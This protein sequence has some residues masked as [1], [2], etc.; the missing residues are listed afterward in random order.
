M[1]MSKKI[2][3]RTVA[4][5]CAALMPLSVLAQDSPAE[6][7]L[8]EIVVTAQKRE[9]RLQDVPIAVSV[10]SGAIAESGGGFN[11][12]ALRSLVPSLNIRKTNTSLNQSL[13]LR[14]VG[15]INF[16]IAAQPSVATVLDGV[17]LSS[18][19]EAFGDLYDIE[20]VEVLRGPQGTLFGK[21]ASAGVVNIVSKRPGDT[22]GGYVDFGWY[23]DNE[24][25]IESVGRDPSCFTRELPVAKGPFVL[26]LAM[27]STAKG[28]GQIFFT[29]APKDGFG[30]AKSVNFS[31]T[32]DGGYH[33]YKIALGDAAHLYALRIDPATAPGSVTIRSLVLRDASGA[34]AKT[35]KLAEA[36]A[37]KVVKHVTPNVLFI[38]LEDSG[39][40]LGLLGTPGLS[41]P[42][43]DALANDGVLFRKY[44]VGYPVC[45]PSKA[46]LY[47]GLYPHRNGLINNTHNLFKPAA[48]ITASERNNGAYAKNQLKPEVTTLAE[49]LHGRGYHMGVSGKLMNSTMATA[50]IR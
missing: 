2:V 27:K 8:D 6:G 13:F 24:L 21:N 32:H 40:H 15:T 43:L 7:R 46:C 3:A 31:V 35:W 9:Q 11:V 4:A 50:R 29:T 47:S 39:A 33:D 22:S 1:S 41:T 16:A 25:R 26:E 30:R 18:A 5:A 44:F 34:V 12:E 49:I 38:L 36:P 20:R 48:N 14:G 45:S 19:G 17:V 23:Q 28:E 42:N 10:V 37:P